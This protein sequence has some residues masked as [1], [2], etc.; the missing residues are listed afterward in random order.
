MDVFDTLLMRVTDPDVVIDATCA[1][2]A[3]RTDAHLVTVQS[4]R[5]R[6]CGLLAATS[7]SKGFDPETPA[8]P[9]FSTWV[10]MLAGDRLG[11]PEIAS[12]AAEA[13]EFELDTEK[14]CL[15]PNEAVLPLLEQ[16]RKSGVPV[17]ALSDMYLDSGRIGVLLEHH[18]LAGYLSAVV[19]SADHSL[20]KRTGRLFEYGLSGEGF[21]AGATASDILH[22]GDDTHADGKMPTAK[23]MQSIL[24]YD[25]R[26]M[27]SRQLSFYLKRDYPTIAA[28][29]I[30]TGGSAF[31][32]LRGLERAVLV[33][34]SVRRLLIKSPLVQCLRRGCTR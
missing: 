4:A 8:E 17:I 14:L 19:S 23:G 27:C 10:R 21:Y 15:S 1:W 16:A 20:Q 11:E 12:L 25:F 33:T 22:I 3:S 31:G 13:L 28:R 9:Y 24:V 30:E 29:T 34:R 26:E 6:A 5:R 7:V 32:Q 18:G 2:L